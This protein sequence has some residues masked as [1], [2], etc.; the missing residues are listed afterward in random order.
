MRFRIS[1]ASLVLSAA[2]F[3]A[4]ALLLPS[5]IVAQA[6]GPPVFAARSELVVVNVLVKDRKGAYVTGLSR[7]AF[8]VDEDGVRQTIQF[9]AEHDAPAT[10]GLVIDSSGSMAG[11][12]ARV[13][14]AAGAFVETSNAGD[15]IFALAF[16]NRVRSALPST[17]RFTGDAGALREALKRAFRPRGSTALYDAITAGFE[18]LTHGT[19]QRTALV[20]VS[21]GGDNAS[22]A[23]LDEVV[24]MTEA[25]NTVIYTIGLIDRNE[26]TANPRILEQLA[27]TSGGEAFRPR[28]PGQVER[29]LR[30]IANDIRNTYTFGYVSTNTERDYRL[31][32]IHV[33]VQK[34]G[35][36]DLRVR[37]RSGYVAEPR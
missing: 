29:V 1:S 27:Q 24:K 21:D 37:A 26:R 34:P 35:E 23:T 6:Q 8:V 2:L 12:E 36:R 22:R 5:I 10:V 11:V 19:H 20:V 30:L 18:Y 16:N 14:A 32:R 15:E 3:G 4:A 25:S 17:A 9:F 31:R 7:D 28:N 33:A 13:I